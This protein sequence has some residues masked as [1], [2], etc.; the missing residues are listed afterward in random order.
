ML[1]SFLAAIGL[2]IIISLAVVILAERWSVSSA[3]K[4]ITI[5]GVLYIVVAIVQVYL[6]FRKSTILPDQHVSMWWL[7][8]LILLHLIIVVFF[9]FSLMVAMNR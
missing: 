8:F 4:A 7:A 6:W 9:A 5:T 2:N 3:E 1:R